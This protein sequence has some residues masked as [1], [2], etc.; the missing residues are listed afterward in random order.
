[1]DPELDRLLRLPGV[2]EDP[3][4]LGALAHANP[5]LLQLRLLSSASAV[6]EFV[7]ASSC[8][9]PEL[10][11]MDDLTRARLALIN[12]CESQRKMLTTTASVQHFVRLHFPEWE[13]P[14]THAPQPARMAN[15]V[16][17]LF[18]QCAPDTPTF[19][20]MACE[21]PDY[22]VECVVGALR[23]TGVGHS[24]RAAKSAAA[25]EMLRLLER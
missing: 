17:H 21:P 14:T 1:M 20:A 13:A 19:A 12:P 23:T 2:G 3:A 7:R 5:T 15:A 25:M 9:E 16:G 18:T 11:A 24:K 22:R 6:K 8:A 4:L 10:P